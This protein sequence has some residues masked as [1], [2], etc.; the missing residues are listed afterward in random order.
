MIGRLLR[1]ESVGIAV[2]IAVATAAA[3]QTPSEVVA[4]W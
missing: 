3:T 4:W 2:G 1:V